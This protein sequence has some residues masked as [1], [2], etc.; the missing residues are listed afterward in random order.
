MSRRVIVSRV[1]PASLS[2]TMTILYTVL[3]LII[4]T[5]MLV[6]ALVR[7]DGRSIMFAVVMIV[8]YPIFAFVGSWIT[9]SLFNAIARRWGVVELELDDVT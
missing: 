1:D 9:A 5:I 2:R 8:F 6:F 7:G 4:G 3:S